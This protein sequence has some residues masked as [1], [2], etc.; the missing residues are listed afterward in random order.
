[1][2]DFDKSELLFSIVTGFLI[3]ILLVIVL[4]ILKFVWTFSPLSVVAFIVF[5]P[6]ISYIVYKNID[7][8]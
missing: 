8:F 2:N 6:I 3:S 7:S 4:V 1:M 5:T